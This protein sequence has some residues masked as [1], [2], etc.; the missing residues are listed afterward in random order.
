MVNL[1]RKGLTMREILEMKQGSPEWHKFRL[2][3]IG[4]SDSA[5]VMEENPWR[6]RLEVWREKVGI[7]KIAELNDAMHQGNLLEPIARQWYETLTGELYQPIVAEHEKITH[8]SASLDGISMDRKRAIEIKCGAKAYKQ[9]K[10]GII[11][12]YYNLQCQHIYLV[13]DVESITYI[14]FDPKQ[15]EESIVLNVPR[16]QNKIDWMIKEY[17]IFW[18]SVL[19][20]IHP[21]HIKR[22]YDLVEV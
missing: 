5:A 4:S 22:N 8:L 21:D 9:A 19:D 16:D 15:K 6:S 13:T 18:D 3:H 14:A 12:E 20:F 1:R 10:E 2:D 7:S 11:P 17:Q